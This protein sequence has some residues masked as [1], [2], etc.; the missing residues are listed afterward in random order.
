MSVKTALKKKLALETAEAVKPDVSD[1]ILCPPDVLKPWPG[2]PR[3]HNEK[4]LAAIMTSITTFGFTAPI[5]TNEERVVLAGH[6]RLEAGIRLGLKEVPT[7]IIAGL[8]QAKQRAYV[9][10][11]NKVSSMSKWDDAL[12]KNEIELLIEEDFNIELTGFSTAEIDLMIDDAPKPETNDPD[13]LLPEDI[14]EEVISQL[15]DVWIL[16]KHRLFC[17]SALEQESYAILMEGKEAQMVVTD[18]PY[19]VKI[20]GHVCGNGTVQH[21]EFAMASGEMSQSEFTTFLRSAFAHINEFC[22]DGAI[23]YSFMDWRHM[24]EILDAGEPVFGPIKQLCVWSKDTGG[25]G[26]FYRSQHELV[27]IFKKGQ[28]THINNFGLGQHGRYRTNIWNYSGVN[29][30]KGKG[31]ELLKLHP[32]VKSTSMIADAIRDCSHR[33]GLILDPF[34][35]SGTILLAAERT[36]RYARAIE[37][38]PKYVDTAIRR[39]ERV[40]GNLAVHAETGLTFSEL[41][42]IRLAEQGDKA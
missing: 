39:W 29:T 5:L 42:D 3:T 23:V 16:G 4:Q 30:F 21:D 28:A 17:G 8:S 24:R 32:T 14:A 6:G 25:M 18:P 11:D 20:D 34:A 12:L 37:L 31:Y 33:K 15:N 41:R 7:R 9:L 38:E 26:T 22:Q 1:I 36:G 40:T 35:G 27:F 2:N 19:N 10:A 13:D